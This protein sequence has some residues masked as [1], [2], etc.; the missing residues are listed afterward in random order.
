MRI[1]LF[2]FGFF[3]LV[4]CSS[5]QNVDMTASLENTNWILIAMDEKPYKPNDVAKPVTLTLQSDG[6]RITGFGGCNAFS[7]SYHL[8]GDSIQFTI[9]STKM[10]CNETMHVEDYLFKALTKTTYSIE[11]DFLTVKN[12]EGQSV[13]FKKS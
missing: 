9:L 1:F 2:V 13:K 11:G 10:Y 12:T 5:S 4:D 7:G 6:N 8:N 3:A